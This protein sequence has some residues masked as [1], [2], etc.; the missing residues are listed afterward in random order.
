MTL[1]VKLSS[2]FDMQISDTK[3]YSG[4]NTQAFRF[5]HTSPLVPQA[6]TYNYSSVWPVLK[7]R[8]VSSFKN[9]N[10]YVTSI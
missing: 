7:K 10:A 8:G 6:I 2:P 1:K 9:E 3:H 4:H 5:F